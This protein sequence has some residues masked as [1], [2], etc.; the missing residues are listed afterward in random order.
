MTDSALLAERAMLR[1]ELA[2]ELNAETM[3]SGSLLRKV[4]ESQ[5]IELDDILATKVAALKDST[6]DTARM[7]ETLAVFKRPF[8]SGNATVIAYAGRSKRRR[9]PGPV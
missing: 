6:G 7:L 5:G 3:F 8:Y 9:V 4:R 1:E 2:Q